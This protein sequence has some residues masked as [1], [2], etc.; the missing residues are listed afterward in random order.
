[1][2]RIANLGIVVMTASGPTSLVDRSSPLGLL[3]CILYLLCA[4]SERACVGLVTTHDVMFCNRLLRHICLSQK[5]TSCLE[6][7]SVM[8]SKVTRAST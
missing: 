6:S 7:L 2:Y 8:V 3:H 4:V 5:H 1:M